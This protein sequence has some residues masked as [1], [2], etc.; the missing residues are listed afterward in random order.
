MRTEEIKSLKTADSIYWIGGGIIKNKDTEKEKFS[1]SNLVSLLTTQIVQEIP[2]AIYLSDSKFIA[3]QEH[4]TQ[5]VQK[6]IA[7]IGKIEG[8]KN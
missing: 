4:L 3:F 5:I 7:K 8:L 1:V 2:G 6:E